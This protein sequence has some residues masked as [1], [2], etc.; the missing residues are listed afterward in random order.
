[1]VVACSRSCR[2]RNSP[3]MTWRNSE[4]S[5][6]SGSSIRN[7]LGLR[8]MA[9]PSA[10]RC[11]SPEERPE[12]ERSSSDSIWRMRAASATRFARSARAHALRLQRKGDVL[13]HAHMRIEREELEHEGD[14]ALGGA[15]ERDVLAVRAGCGPE[16][17]S[18][19]P[20]IMRSVVVLPQPDGPSRQKNSPSFDHEVGALDGDEIAEGLVQ[21]VNLDLGHRPPSPRKLRDDDEHDRPAEDGHEGIGVERQPERLAQHDD[22]RPR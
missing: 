4:S 15:P 5:A 12:T 22:A 16:V 21:L 2:A 10:T 3:V 7:A 17:G 8:T 14:V 11:R 13:A 9:R 19:R 18:S 6:P 1:M 20:A